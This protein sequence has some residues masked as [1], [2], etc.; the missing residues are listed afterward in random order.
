[1][2]NVLARRHSKVFF[3]TLRE[4]G[5]AVEAR[6]IENFGYAQLSSA[7][8]LRCTFEFD[9]ADEVVDSFSG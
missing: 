8:V 9:R 2:F 6:L 7:E 5:M 3:E 4:V 1:M